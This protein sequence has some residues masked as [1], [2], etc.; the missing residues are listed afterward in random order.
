MFHT[1][2]A[3]IIA[4]F[5]QQ[6]CQHG[7]HYALIYVDAVNM[8]TGQLGVKMSSNVEPEKIAGLLGSLLEPGE[9]VR[10]MLTGLF[11]A[12]PLRLPATPDPKNPPAADATPVLV[13][14]PVD[15]AVDMALTALLTNLQIKGAKKASPIV[16]LG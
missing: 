11:K 16:L 14:V 5:N 12:H 8:T 9:Q 2:I 3:N 15:Q 4:N 13:E 10:S 1:P 7:C 6:L